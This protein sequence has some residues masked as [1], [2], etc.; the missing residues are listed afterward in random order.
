[1][2]KTSLILLIDFTSRTELQRYLKAKSVSLL[3]EKLRSSIYRLDKFYKNG[4]PAFIDF[5]VIS[6]FIR[7]S[8]SSLSLVILETVFKNYMNPL[9]DISELNNNNNYF[10]KSILHAFNLGMAKQRSPIAYIPSYLIELHE[11]FRLS[12]SIC[13]RE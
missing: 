2:S 7:F 8:L 3:F 1:M 11:T 10:L 5:Y 13:C 6:L 4:D 9:S 12:Y